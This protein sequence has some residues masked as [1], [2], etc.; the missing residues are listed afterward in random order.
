MCFKCNRVLSQLWINKIIF[1]LIQSKFITAV[2]LIQTRSKICHSRYCSFTFG[3]FIYLHFL[4]THTSPLPHKGRRWVVSSYVVPSWLYEQVSDKHEWWSITLLALSSCVDITVSLLHPVSGFAA[5]INELCKADTGMSAVPGSTPC[6]SPL[7]ASTRF[8]SSWVASALATSWGC[9]GMR[10]WF[11]RMLSP[12]IPS[13]AGHYSQSLEGGRKKGGRR[14]S[15]GRKEGG[16]SRKTFSGGRTESTGVDC[17]QGWPFSVRD[18][19]ND[20]ARQALSTAGRERTAHQRRLA[21]SFLFLPAQRLM[22]AEWKCY[23]LKMKKWL[24]K[25]FRVVLTFHNY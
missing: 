18:Q 5:T 21:R 9:T 8:H 16:T 12:L 6:W 20:A 24:H 13:P 1:N 3:Q 17:T 25:T 15:G 7:P 2:F 11:G 4:V 10:P 19:E 23:A 14:G 22:Q